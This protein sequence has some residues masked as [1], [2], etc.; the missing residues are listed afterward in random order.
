MKKKGKNVVRDTDFPG[1][2]EEKTHDTSSIWGV[3]SDSHNL[4]ETVNVEQPQLLSS[5]SVGKKKKSSKGQ[6]VLLFKVGL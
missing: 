4:T 3:G 5:Q 2:G 6:K 1:L